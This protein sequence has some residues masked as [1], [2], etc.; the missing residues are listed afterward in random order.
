MTVKVIVL[1]L[2]VKNISSKFFISVSLRK[3]LFFEMK[4]SGLTL[5]FMR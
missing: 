3:S 2:Y 4:V 1:N 5:F